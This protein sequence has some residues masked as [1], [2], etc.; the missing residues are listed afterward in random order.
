MLDTRAKQAA[1]SAVGGTVLA[2]VITGIGKKI[3]G[4]KVFTRENLGIPGFD[5]PSIKVQA[6]SELQKIKLQNEA[7]KKDRDV[8]ARK[9]IEIDEPE[10]VKDIP[11]SKTKLLRGPRY[12]FREN[13]VKPYEMKFG[14]PALNYLTNGEYGAEAGGAA[15]GGVIGYAS[16]DEDT[17][18]TTK[19]GRAFTGALVGAGGIKA[20]R[21][22]TLTKTF[23][24][25][26]D[27]TEEVTESL[28]DYLGRQFVDGYGLPKNFKAMQAEAQGFSNHIAM[29]FTYMANK[30]QKNLTPDEQKVILN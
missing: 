4:E 9:K 22:K 18:I 14:K 21:M 12:W 7:G 20:A 11:S 1:F 15:T 2:P 17:P 8:V 23:G 19:F 16:G 25:G 10:V 28:L 6:D 30:I 27:K 26:E 13:V 3:K 5:T 29:K 24:K